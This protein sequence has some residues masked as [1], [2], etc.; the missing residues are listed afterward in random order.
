MGCGASRSNSDSVVTD[1][2]IS[3][4]QDTL[5]QPVS[6]EISPIVDNSEQINPD[7]V[8]LSNLSRVPSTLEGLDE[9]TNSEG[10]NF[11]KILNE[12]I[13]RVDD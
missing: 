8:K 7:T 11:V 12:L 10:K 3:N 1:N 9:A 5:R 4:K 13:C 2:E 6:I